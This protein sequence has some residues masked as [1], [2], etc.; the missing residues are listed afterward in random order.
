MLPEE[1]VRVEKM[2]ENHVF[3]ASVTI[4]IAEKEVTIKVMNESRFVLPKMCLVLSIF[5]T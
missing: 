4:R 5:M 1:V 3:Q 2:T